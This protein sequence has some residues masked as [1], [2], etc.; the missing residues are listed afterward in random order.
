MCELVEHEHFAFLRK[1]SE[2]ALAC[3]NLGDL[4]AL[5]KFPSHGFICKVSSTPEN[6]SLISKEDE[7]VLSDIK[8]D[9]FLSLVGVIADRGGQQSLFVSDVSELFGDSH[10]SAIVL[11]PSVQIAVAEKA[12]CEF[13]GGL[14][15]LHGEVVFVL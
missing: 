11:A 7:C 2:A 14:D 3:N 12:D 9:D 5:R 10:G 15:L 4:D 13:G 6:L 8:L 1:S